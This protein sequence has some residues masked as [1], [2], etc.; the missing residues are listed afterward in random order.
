MAAHV[1]GTDDTGRRRWQRGDGG[2]FGSVL[3]VGGQQD[4]GDDNGEDAGGGQERDGPAATPGRRIS[5]V[6]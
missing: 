5:H 3:L 6:R 4:A 2:A 1:A